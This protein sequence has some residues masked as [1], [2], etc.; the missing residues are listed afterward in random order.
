M[1]VDPRLLHGCDL[2]ELKKT[3]L[4]HIGLS[5]CVH[6]TD[7]CILNIVH[8]CCKLISVDLSGC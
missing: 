2:L 1:K 3:D 5:D 7:A 4:T 8:E 6:I